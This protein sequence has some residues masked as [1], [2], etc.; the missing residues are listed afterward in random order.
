MFLADHRLGE[1]RRLSIVAISSLSCNVPRRDPD[2]PDQRRRP[3]DHLAKHFGGPNAITEALKGST[4]KKKE[5]R[6]L[7]IRYRVGFKF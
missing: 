1:G 2:R 4:V 7:E 3:F 5:W 6:Y